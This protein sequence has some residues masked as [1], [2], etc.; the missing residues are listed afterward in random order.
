[1]QFFR[2][3]L[4]KNEIQYKEKKHSAKIILE[5]IIKLVKLQSLVAKCCR[6]LEG[7]TLKPWERGWEGVAL[8]GSQILRS[9]VLREEIATT[10][11]PKMVAIFARNAG[12]C[13]VCKLFRA[14][15]SA[16]YGSS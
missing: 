5:S 15:F 8:Q 1:M 14:M 6:V 12:V 16:F 13:K 10:F 4:P 11:G 9:F 2:N 7:V 3:T